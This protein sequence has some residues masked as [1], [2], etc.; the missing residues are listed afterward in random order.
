MAAVVGGAAELQIDVLEAM[1]ALVS[2]HLIERPQLSDGEPRFGLLQTV[3]EFAIEQLVAAGEL[4]SAQRRHAEV[5]VALAERAATEL[6]GSDQAPWL[7]SVER[8]HDNLRVALQWAIDTATADLGLRLGAAVEAFWFHRGYLAEGRA[9]LGRLLALPSGDSGGAIRAAVLSQSATMA[10]VVG[11]HA[12][13]W[14]LLQE[15]LAIRRELAD[16][17][18]IVECLSRLGGVAADRGDLVTARSLLERALSD[19]VAAGAR[20]EEATVLARLGEVCH[21]QGNLRRARALLEQSLA[22][23]REFGGRHTYPSLIR[24]GHVAVD[25]GDFERAK[26]LFTEA[27]PIYY[28][29]FDDPWRVALPLENFALL[30]VAQGQAERGLHLA[31][32]AAAI[33]SARDVTG[34]YYF[35]AARTRAERAVDQARLV[36]GE[37]V[38]E[39][40]WAAGQS[41]SAAQAVSYALSED[42]ASAAA[43]DRPAH[44]HNADS[45]GP[46]TPREQQVARLVARGL[47]NL[48]IAGE[49]IVTER[50]VENHISHILS[51]LGMRTRTQVATWAAVLGLIGPRENEC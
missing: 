15:T 25:Q 32:A 26:A 48:Q 45:A 5:C 33:R 29:A 36:L 50:T 6:E 37:D 11:D 46:L 39:A 13:A 42:D 35:R 7:I 22:I 24:L 8:E 30:A 16:P 9:W 31:G 19:C 34:F 20:L 49:L 1:T 23:T 3:R 47:T 41:M 4:Q 14:Q 2:K 27:V 18:P 21:L 12:Q 40:A 10:S 44:T 28:Q 17:L 51:K 43:P 38:S